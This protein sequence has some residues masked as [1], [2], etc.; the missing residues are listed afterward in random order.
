MLKSN[1]CGSGEENGESNL[2]MSASVVHFQ[3]IDYVK[4]NY[5]KRVRHLDHAFCRKNE[6]RC[7]PDH[8]ERQRL[9]LLRL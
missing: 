2:N 3:A 6:L 1:T 8:N 9:T 5:L 7:P 4:N